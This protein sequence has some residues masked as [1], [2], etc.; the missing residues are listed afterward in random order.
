MERTG[1]RFKVVFS[2]LHNVLRSTRQANHPLAHFGTPICIGPLFQ[3]GEWREAR[4]L[5]ERPLASLG[6]RFE[7]PDLVM[8]ML[9]QV[10]FY[11]SLIQLYCDHLLSYMAEVRSGGNE[12]GP[13]FIIRERH[14]DAT[15][16]NPR[17][18]EKIRDRFRWTLQLDERYQVI[19]Y[20]IAYLALGEDQRRVATGFHPLRS[21]MCRWSTGRK[22]SQ[23]R[24]VKTRL[25]SSWMSLLGW[26]FC[27]L[28]GVGSI[29]SQ[30]QPDVPARR[31][32]RGYS[33]PA[34]EEKGA[35]PVYTADTFRAGLGTDHPARLSPLTSRQIAELQ[36][37]HGVVLLAGCPA[38]GLEEVPTALLHAFGKS[39][40]HLKD[41][42]NTASSLGGWMGW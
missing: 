23:V 31:N 27:I 5:A 42:P 30:S 18:K 20:A 35:S 36:D 11:P 7:S 16:R 13:P 14:L 19:A 34:Y 39:C 15:Y 12:P 6:Y 41:G 4:S 3:D 2:G 32:R 33:R 26:E 22:A 1:R 9:S 25:L 8:R 17:L 10:N 28:Q 21:D 29:V 24:A 38:A 40:I 37:G